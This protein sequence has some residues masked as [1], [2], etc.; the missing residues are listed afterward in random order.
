MVW[1]RPLSPPSVLHVSHPNDY[2]KKRDLQFAVSAVLTPAQPALDVLQI[3]AGI[4]TSPIDD[5]CS[6]PSAQIAIDDFVFDQLVGRACCM[7]QTPTKWYFCAHTSCNPL[8]HRRFL[9]AKF[10][11]A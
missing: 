2:A 3:T 1:K 11:A 9:Y 4:S 5:F 7:R 6:Q 10:F 8:R